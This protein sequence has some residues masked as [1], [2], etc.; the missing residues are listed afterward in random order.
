MCQKTEEENN[1][2]TDAL[3]SWTTEALN[4]T[5]QNEAVWFLWVDHVWPYCLFCVIWMRRECWCH[6]VSACWKSLLWYRRVCVYSQQVW[7]QITPPPQAQVVK[8]VACLICDQVDPAAFLMSVLLLY[9]HVFLVFFITCDWKKRI[10]FVYVCVYS[11]VP[12]RV[13]K[14]PQLVIAITF[15]KSVEHNGVTMK[16]LLESTCNRLLIYFISLWRYFEKGVLDFI[17]RNRIYCTY[18]S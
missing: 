14:I 6:F 17:Q 3:P 5:P 15:Q 1:R 2:R 7:D 10:K 9:R 8:R 11:E 16:T 18:I 13:R 4:V 12:I